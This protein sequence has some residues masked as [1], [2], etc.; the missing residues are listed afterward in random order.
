M[1]Q[2]RFTIHSKATDADPN[3][4]RSTDVTGA[5]RP[6]RQRARPAERPD[7]LDVM[8]IRERSR[9]QFEP[10]PMV[11][12]CRS[13]TRQAAADRAARKFGGPASELG[14]GMS[15]RQRWGAFLIQTGRR[16]LTVGQARSLR[17][18][19]TGEELDTL[20]RGELLMIG[21]KIW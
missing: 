20:S 3:G 2:G 8:E 17:R 9:A 11:E 13:G 7:Q 16:S 18:R 12:L 21:A 6:V 10:N 4:L 1:V 15:I 5:Q 19:S 14:S